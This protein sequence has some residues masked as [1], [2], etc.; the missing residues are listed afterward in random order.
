MSLYKILKYKLL[1]AFSGNSAIFITIV[2]SICFSFLIA[3]TFKYV[4][5]TQ[6]EKSNV[7]NSSSIF[8]TVFTL[9]LVLDVITQ[10][11][12]AFNA[13][14]LLFVN[15]VIKKYLFVANLIVAFIFSSF[16]A[17]F[18][19]F[20]LLIFFGLI[21][22]FNLYMLLLLILFAFF[23]AIWGTFFSALSLKSKSGSV[24][25]YLLYIPIILVGAG[26]LSHLARIQP[27]LFFQDQAF[28]TFIG[29]TAIGYFLGDS[30]YMN[31]IE[32]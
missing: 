27:S 15:N 28:F 12:L 20:L 1:V 2:H 10:K 17:V 16:L 9:I 4:G 29:I 14:D 21:A 6:I 30:F 23:L 18:N 11:D 13:F 7:I 19:Y 25:T 26:L 32:E 24:M 31:L 8:I 3:I 22:E 5:I